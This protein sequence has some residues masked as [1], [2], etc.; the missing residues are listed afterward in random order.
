MTSLFFIRLFNCFSLCL[1]AL[2]DGK[3]LEFSANILVSY[4]LSSIIISSSWF[5]FY[6]GKYLVISLCY[7]SISIRVDWE[8]ALNLAYIR[9]ELFLSTLQSFIFCPFSYIINYSIFMYFDILLPIV[10]SKVS[11]LS[12]SHLLP[13]NIFF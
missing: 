9:I 2:F 6:F 4:S 13:V 12:V 1:F 5:W 11:Y 10:H 8:P 7:F 3:P